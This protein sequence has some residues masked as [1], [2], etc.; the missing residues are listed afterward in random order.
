MKKDELTDLL[1]IPE[2][3]IAPGDDTPLLIGDYDP[4]RVR[5]W[6]DYLYGEWTR[7]S[8]ELPG[9]Y[10][11]ATLDGD[12]VGQREYIQREGRVIDPRRAVGEPGWQGWFWSVARPAP[13]KGVPEE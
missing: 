8:P 7:T 3:A 12:F 4:E 6:L 13:P 2:P 1:E 11:V 9:V 5:P 10:D